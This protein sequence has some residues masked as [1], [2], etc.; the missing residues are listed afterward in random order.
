EVGERLPGGPLEGEVVQAVRFAEVV[1]ADHTWMH[2]AGP[3]SRFPQKSFDHNGV[4][5]ET[6]AQYFERTGA[7]LGMLG[8]VHLRR[9]SFADALE[10]AVA[11]DRPAGQV[12]GGHG[13]CARNYRPASRLGK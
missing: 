6:L 9:S 13:G 10:E 1:G 11:G 5:P 2:D 4:A 8:A 3:V 12:F 7:A